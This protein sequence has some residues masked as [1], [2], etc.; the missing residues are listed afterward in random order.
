MNVKSIWTAALIGVVGFVPAQAAAQILQSPRVENRTST[1]RQR[2]VIRQREAARQR[3]EAQQRVE[4]RRGGSIFDRDIDGN[5]KRSCAHLSKLEKARCKEL[6]K[7]EH[8][9]AKLEKRRQHCLAQHRSNPSHPHCQGTNGTWS[10][11]DRLPDVIYGG[12]VRRPRGTVP[13]LETNR[14]LPRSGL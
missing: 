3:A 8:R 2:A 12:D 10:V 14:R 6:R 11:R 9:L 1:A 4:D 7:E 5:R 13:A